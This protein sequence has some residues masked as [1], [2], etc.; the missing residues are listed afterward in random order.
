MEANGCFHSSTIV[1]SI[2]T[3]SMNKEI[4]TNYGSME[5]K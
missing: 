3:T 4:E 5:A 2:A 1:A